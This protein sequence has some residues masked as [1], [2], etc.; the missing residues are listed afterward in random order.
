[1][2]DRFDSEIKGL[3]E[4][5][6]PLARLLH[7]LAQTLEKPVF[8]KRDGG[9]RFK[10]PELVHFCLL[11]GVRIVSALSASIE[12]AR[13]GFTQEVVTL[14][15]TMI[16]YSTQIDF[17]LASLDD[18]KSLSPDASAFLSNYFEDAAR[19]NNEFSKK[20]KLAQ[21][22][23][24]EKIGERLDSFAIP[25]GNRKPAAQLLSNVYGNFSNYVHGRY[26]EAMD[27]YGGIP[28][29]FHMNGMR[30]TPKDGENIKI[31][32]TMITS[33]SNC[34]LGVVQGLNLRPLIGSDPMLAKWY[35]D[36]VS[37]TP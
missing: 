30:G 3:R 4:R 2:Q 35:R 12:L 7:E 9:F 8:V 17:M 18:K 23:V 25:G 10:R 33:A 1:L 6:F 36:G 13:N 21:K 16:E 15:R 14:L 19:D 20:A 34:F 28:G 26:P 5:V 32:D 24:H 31:L 27:L 11:R 37:K 22:K 29:R